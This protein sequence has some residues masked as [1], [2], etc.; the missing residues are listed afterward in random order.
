MVPCIDG[1]LRGELPDQ[2]SWNGQLYSVIFFQAP[3]KVPIH[4][5]DIWLEDF[6]IG[7]VEVARPE[8]GDVGGEVLLGQEHGPPALAP[9][10]GRT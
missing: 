7:P 3:S 10:P 8:D 1:S 6:P 2:V 5:K 4:L 9:R